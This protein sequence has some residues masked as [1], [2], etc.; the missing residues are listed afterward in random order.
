MF[1]HF[2]RSALSTLLITSIITSS[3]A[4]SYAVRPEDLSTNHNSVVII[5]PSLSLQKEE[6]EEHNDPQQ[7]EQL[8][9][10]LSSQ[11]N[12]G[13]PQTILSC[14]DD[15]DIQEMRLVSKAWR[16][17][18]EHFE[19]QHGTFHA[20]PDDLVGF[21][22]PTCRY[23][24][25]AVDRGV[26][27]ANLIRRMEW[28]MHSL[29]VM[30]RDHEALMALL[31]RTN[32]AQKLF[33]EVLEPITEKTLHPWLS[34][35]FTETPRQLINLDS[36][37]INVQKAK[38]AITLLSNIDRQLKTHKDLGKAPR[39]KKLNVFIDQ[40]VRDLTSDPD[41][42]GQTI[43][44][45]AQVTPQDHQTLENF[46][47]R[48]EGILKLYTRSDLPILP[49]TRPSWFLVP[50]LEDPDTQ[51][52]THAAMYSQLCIRPSTYQKILLQERQIGA[53]FEPR[54]G[55][56]LFMFQMKEPFEYTLSR[57]PFKQRDAILDQAQELLEPQN[58]H[59]LQRVLHTL[60]SFPP[61]GRSHVVQCAKQII[62]RNPRILTSNTPQNVPLQTLL[63]TLSE[64]SP[65]QR[66]IA[67]NRGALFMFLYDPKKFS[68]EIRNAGVESS[69]DFY[70]FQIVTNTKI[71]I[72]DPIFRAAVLFGCTYNETYKEFIKYTIG[73][74]YYYYGLLM[75]AT[76]ASKPLRDFIHQKVGI[77]HYIFVN[78]CG[79]LNTLIFEEPSIP[80]IAITCFGLSFSLY[81]LSAFA[82]IILN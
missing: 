40:I 19:Q 57:I 59:L 11:Y 78:I 15:V 58:G 38:T 5:P 31:Q 49:N 14:L 61:S 66:E 60:S 3:I 56:E 6:P 13:I 75:Y 68:G 48:Y 62:Q 47:E 81:I 25:V 51:W 65:E 1:L 82:P 55:F 4:P 42:Q 79:F 34:R 43:T 63:T 70:K 53:F 52:M 12:S 64:M 74:G 37:S 69:I 36:L 67:A 30:V 9:M 16:R 17:A 80:N 29:E 72:S 73:S 22:R 8:G 27:D 20:I 32:P 39:L 77:H 18:V 54:R 50:V 44:I 24:H 26:L 46:K 2:M 41:D 23:A 71:V 7:L 76:L 10:A 45:P 21:L 35:E 28:K 33:V